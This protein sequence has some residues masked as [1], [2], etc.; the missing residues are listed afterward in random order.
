[1]K[2]QDQGEWGEL[3]ALLRQDSAAQDPGDHFFE[4]MHDDIMA[5]LPAQQPVELPGGVAQVNPA[6]PSTPWFRRLVEGFGRRPTLAW[7]AVMAVALLGLVFWPAEQASGP[8]APA[9]STSP[10]AV[11]QQ[12][13][14]EAEVEELRQ[15]AAEMKIDILSEEDGWG[16]VAQEDAEASLGGFGQEDLGWMDED[17]LDRAL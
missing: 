7:G 12:D 17:D 5:Q 2:Q 11:A 14:T 13:L 8:V 1:M 10:G 3:E 15:L 4:A 9:P 6:A 16:A